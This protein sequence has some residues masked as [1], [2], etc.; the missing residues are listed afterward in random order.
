MQRWTDEDLKAAVATCKTWKEICSKLGLSDNN[1]NVKRLKARTEELKL[2]TDNMLWQKRS[3]TAQQLKEAAANSRSYRQMLMALGLAEYGSAYSFIKTAIEEVG[4][5]ISHFSHKGW[6]KGL[7]YRPRPKQDLSI[8]LVENSVYTNVNALRK[9]L[10][11]E[12]VFDHICSCC[13][14]SEWMGQ[15]IPIEL[16]HINGIKADNRIENLR[17]LCPNCHAQTTTYRGKNMKSA[18]DQKE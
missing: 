2:S 11:N 14:N 1:S 16:D 12:G 6:N 8:I 13:G 3:Y 4:V 9:R 5:D 15:K 17:L 7:E 18:K 10:I